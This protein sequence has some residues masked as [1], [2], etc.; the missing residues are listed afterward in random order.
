MFY[1]DDEDDT[2]KQNLACSKSGESL[3]N[4]RQKIEENSTNNNNNNN[5]NRIFEIIAGSSSSSTNLVS[6]QSRKKLEDLRDVL[7]CLERRCRELKH[8][9][10]P[11]YIAEI[12]NYSEHLRNDIEIITQSVLEYVNRFHD[13]LMKQVSK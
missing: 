5:E 9:S 7:S 8:V 2:N 6:S 3:E 12:R 13:K 4:E 1:D 11:G 10:A